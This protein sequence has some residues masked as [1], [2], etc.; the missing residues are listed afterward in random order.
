MINVF[1]CWFN[2]RTRKRGCRSYSVLNA[3]NEVYTWRV[4][5]KVGCIM[6]R[7]FLGRPSLSRRDV[8]LPRR[9]VILT[10]LC[11]VATWYS[12][13]ATSLLH[14]ATSN[15]KALCHVATWNSHVA[16]WTSHVATS[17]LHVATSFGHLLCHVATLL[18]TSRHHLVMLSATSRRC[19]ARRDVAK[20]SSL[21]RRDVTPHFA[22]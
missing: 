18:R 5:E 9:D 16:T 20:L 11:H 1:V 8:E 3:R 12:H 14:V 2:F 4:L 17:L 13:V 21:S 7:K 6:Y 22:T 10:L 19:P 15:C